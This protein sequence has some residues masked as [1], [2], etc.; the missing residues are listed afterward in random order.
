M[1]LFD[2]FDRIIN[3]R[4]PDLLDKIQEYKERRYYRDY[5]SQWWYSLPERVM[6]EHEPI[7]TLSTGRCGTALLTKV[8]RQSPR[9]LCY[10]SPSPEMTYLEKRAYEEGRWRFDSFKEAILAARFELIADCVVRQRTYI[11]TNCRI[12]FFCR[13]LSELFPRSKFIHLVRH[14]G[15]FVRSGALRN[16]Y[17]GGYHDMGRITPLSGVAAQKWGDMTIYERCAWLWNETNRHVEE[18]KESIDSPRIITVKSEDLF[19]DPDEASR[20]FSHC[21]LKPVPRNKTEKIIRRPVNAQVK[22]KSDLLPY[23]HW[24]EITKDQVR[25]WAALASR[26]GYIL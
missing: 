2:K 19:S 1:G 22:R 14:P 17:A 25:Q 9:A 26:Y 3:R 23:K 15:D 4:L 12:T 24:D 8:L 21:S 16:Y 13:H 20:I 5:D 10:H 7:F 6:N 18:F 11:E